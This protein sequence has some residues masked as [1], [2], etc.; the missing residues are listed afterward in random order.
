MKMK[1]LFKVGKVS[2]ILLLSFFSLLTQDTLKLKVKQDKAQMKAKKEELSKLRAKIVSPD[3]ALELKIKDC[4]QE[5]KEKEKILV[6]SQE[7][8]EKL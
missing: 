6:K 1:G 8:L 3:Q 4:E 5:E 7:E 2:S